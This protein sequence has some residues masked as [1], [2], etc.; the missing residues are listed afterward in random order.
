[1]YIGNASGTG[2]RGA[3]DAPLA[4]R[5]PVAHDALMTDDPRE[6]RTADGRRAALRLAAAADRAGI[7]A[8]LEALGLPTAGVAEWLPHFHVAED[9][10]GRL[11]GVAGVELYGEGALLRSVGV[12]PGWRST[13]LG[14][15]LVDRALAAA[16]AAGALEIY[17]LTTT[18]ETWFPRL[19][20][21]P[22]PREGVPAQVRGSVEFREACPDSAV[23][24]RRPL[25][26][27]PPTPRPPLES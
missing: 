3:A 9:E 17:L 8:L 27:P 10:A 13:G 15:A 23:V 16:R 22:T 18:A 14:R 7:E 25:P 1:M 26:T 6:F 5:R 19:G 11:V 4:P 12:D 21:T 20:F 24:M 2:D